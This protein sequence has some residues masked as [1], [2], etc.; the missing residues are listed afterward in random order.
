MLNVIRDCKPEMKYSS[1]RKFVSNNR[2]FKGQ[3]LQK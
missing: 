1:S 2:E 3:L